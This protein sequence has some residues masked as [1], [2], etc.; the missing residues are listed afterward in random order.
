MSA[1]TFEVLFDG[2]TITIAPSE[3]PLRELKP[4]V[5]TSRRGADR[6]GERDGWIC[7]ICGWPIPKDGGY[8]RRLSS[9]GPKTDLLRPDTEH[10]LAMAN[11]GPDDDSNRWIAHHGCNNH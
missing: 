6:I 3:L 5:S 7:H 8:W 4:R 9:G 11:G 10:K 2:L 1:P